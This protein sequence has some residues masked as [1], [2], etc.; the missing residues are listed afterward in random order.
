MSIADDEADPWTVFWTDRFPTYERCR[1]MKRHQKV[2]HIPGILSICRKDELARNLTKLSKL[3]PKQYDF[4][5]KTWVL[6]GELNG[7]LKFAKSAKNKI[8][9]LKPSR[10]SLGRGI[11]LTRSIEHFDL[12]KMMIGQVYIQRP[13]LIDG[14]KFDLRLYVLVASCSPLRVF[15]YNEGLA[16]FA[17]REYQPTG[18]NLHV[19]Y[20]HLTN[21]SVNKNSSTFV[22][23]EHA[24]SKR[25]LSTIRE[26]L[27][28]RDYN[29]EKVW[30][31]IDDAIVKTILTALPHMR[32]HYSACFP[33]HVDTV[34]A[35]ELLGF[36][37][38]L[39]HKLKP[40]LLEVNHTPSFTRCTPIDREVKDRL[41]HDVFEILKL[42]E[43]DSQRIKN[44]ENDFL[45]NRL[46]HK[47]K[48]H[49][50]ERE[51]L[52]EIVK[53]RETWEMEHSG[54]FRLVYPA[55]NAG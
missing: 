7:L 8:F 22:N 2:N 49:K 44:D 9:I 5:P 16:R 24:G 11:Y 40:Y 37:F 10:G 48:A 6:P 55:S 47:S 4:F 54:D 28:S 43:D 39:D 21:Y 35:F 15:V 32:R 29:A 17:T 31:S 51:R 19:K 26:W 30:S 3:F 13:F 45:Q 14:F 33:T 25:K 46:S 12:L 42:A 38:I 18:N 52:A 41:M 23:D 1:L 50:L 53:E 20:M 27:T 34:A 36:D